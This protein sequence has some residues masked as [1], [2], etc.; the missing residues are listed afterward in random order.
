M[1][2]KTTQL[3][4]TMQ[5]A[6]STSEHVFTKPTVRYLYYPRTGTPETYTRV[7]AIAYTYNKSSD[8]STHVRY[9]ASVYRRDYIEDENGNK[10]YN[11]ETFTNKMR[12]GI[13]DTAL[14]RFG[15]SPVEY[16]ITETTPKE[17]RKYNLTSSDTKEFNRGFREF[18]VFKTRDMIGKLGVGKKTRTTI[19]ETTQSISV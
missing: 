19:H 2:G 8:G 13:R 4:Q 11:K 17:Q 9:G 15:T 5:Q 10:V 6:D 16:N 1:E 14:K 18:V 12:N 7:F 3:A